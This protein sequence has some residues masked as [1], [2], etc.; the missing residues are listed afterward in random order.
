MIHSFLLIIILNSFLLFF[1]QSCADLLFC[2]AWLFTLFN[3]HL[4]HY[5]HFSSLFSNSFIFM[6]IHVDFLQIASFGDLSSIF[7]SDGEIWGRG[8]FLGLE[9]Y[10]CVI[11]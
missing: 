1:Y 7:D 2:F 9:V 3:I 4:F 6:D 11:I 5:Q 8:G 10:G